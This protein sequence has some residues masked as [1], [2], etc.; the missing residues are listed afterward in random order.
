[1]AAIGFRPARRMDGSPWNGA[2]VR[3][4]VLSGIANIF[5]G[6][7]VILAGTSSASPVDGAILNDLALCTAGG[8]VYGVVTGV[9]PVG[10]SGTSAPNLQIVYGATNAYREVLVA[11]VSPE[12]VFEAT[13]DTAVLA[14]GAALQGTMYDVTPTV[15]T[16]TTQGI[17]AHVLAQASASTTS[18]GWMFL[19][20]RNDPANIGGLTSGTTVVASTSASPTIIEVVCTEPQVHITQLGAGV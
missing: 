11:V 19:G 16:N 15:S 20:V 10:T 6:D 5:I 17:S 4:S 12:L 7:S 9:I 3:C 1:M 8:R 14:V 18:A 2:V 13:I